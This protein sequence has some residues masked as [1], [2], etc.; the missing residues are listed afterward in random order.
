[1]I[2]SI[3][4]ELPMPTDAE[5][6]SRLRQMLRTL[7]ADDRQRLE[8][9]LPLRQLGHSPSPPPRREPPP[10]SPGPRRP[11][12]IPPPDP[13]RDRP[14]R[15]RSATTAAQTRG[16]AQILKWISLPFPTTAV[17]YWTL[18]A[19]ARSTTWS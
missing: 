16:Q 7:L 4:G 5:R 11:G 3:K 8:D 1:M 13:A 6:A 12:Q 15:A 10:L 18:C 2:Y 14:S 19:K 17:S 9:L